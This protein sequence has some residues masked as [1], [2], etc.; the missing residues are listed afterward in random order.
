MHLTGDLAYILDTA[1]GGQDRGKI[2]I[3]QAEIRQKVQTKCSTRQSGV[4]SESKHKNP[5]KWLPKNDDCRKED[6]QPKMKWPT[7]PSLDENIRQ[8]TKEFCEWVASLEL[9]SSQGQADDSE[10]GGEQHNIEESTIMSLFASGYQTKPTFRVPIQVVELDN[11]PMELRMSASA[12]PPFTVAKLPHLKEQRYNVQSNYCPSQ[13][14]IRYGAW[15][16]NPE[17]W[18]KQKADELL[19]ATDIEGVNDTVNSRS[20]LNEKNIELLQLHGTAA[21]KEFIEKRGYRRPSVSRHFLQINLWMRATIF[22]E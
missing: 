13:V 19:K 8:M 22:C 1:N 5:Y 11:I 14:K 2:V 6:K 10:T 12:T 20:K 17:T 7:S 4:S 21:F 18:E 3:K 9:L 15:Y 16:L